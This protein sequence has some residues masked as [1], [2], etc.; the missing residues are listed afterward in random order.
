[1]R[2]LR[3]PLL[4]LALPVL[5][6]TA[7]RPAQGRP[8]A[9]A[10][11]RGADTAA[12]GGLPAGALSAFRFRGIGPAFT[13]GRIGDIA[14]HPNKT[15]WYVAVASGGV[16]KTENAGTTW[17]PIFD[18]QG[19]YSIGTVT[20]DP[21]DPNTIWVGTGENN[22]QRSV[23]YGDGVYKS[24]DGG[25][26]WRNM[27]LKASEHIGMIAIDPRDSRVVYV[28]A[29]G[30]LWSEGGDRGLYKTTDGGETWERILA[31]AKW[32]GVNEV[33][34]DPRNPDIVLASTWQ[35][36]RH[37]WGYLAGGPESALHRSTDGGRTWKKLS[38]VP[39]GEGRIGLARSPSH[40]DVVYAIV[41]A[42]NNRG[43][44]FRSRDN[45]ASWSRQGAYSTISLYYQEIFVDPVNPDRVYAMDVRTMVSND[46]GR[47]FT[48]LGEAGKHVDNHAF[49]A[50][51]DDP[52]HLLIGSDGGLYESFDAGRTYHFFGNLPVTQFYKIDVDRNAP[53][54]NIYGGTQDNFSFGGPSRTTSN[55]GIRN[56]DWFVTN[57]GD[58]FQSRVDPTDHNIIYAESQ[59]GGLVRFDRRTGTSVRIVP[60]PEPG[61]A[62]S[63]WNWDSPILVSPHANTRLYFASQRLYRSDDRGDNWTA[64]SPDLTRNQQR[65]ELRMQGRLWSVDAVARNTSTSYNGNIV[66]LAESPR[67]EGL[68]YVGTDDGLIQV[69]EDNGATWR[70]VERFPGVPDTS[71]IAYV[72]PSAHDAN[73]VYAGINNY[74]RGD[75]RPYVLK[76]TDKGRTWRAITANL[77]ERGSVHVVR[78]DPV[79]AGL[80]F[81]GTEFGIFVSFDDGARWQQLRGGLPPIAVRDIAIQPEMDDLVVATFGRGLYIL[82]DYSALR[83]LTPAALRAEATM[84]P[85]KPALMYSLSSPLGGSGVSFQGASH[86]FAPNPPVGAT[87]TY[88]LRTALRSQRAQRQAREQALNRTGADVPFPG[89]EALKAEQDEEA[90]TVEMEITDPSGA[91]ISRF[92]APGGAGT[93]R[94]TWNLRWPSVAPVAGSGGGGFGGFGGGGGGGG[95][96]GAGAVQ[97]G[98]GPYVVPGTYR[99]QLFKRVDG[100]RSPLTEPAAFDVTLL[101]D[102]TVTPADRA[103]ALAFQRRAQELQRVVLGANA[104]MAETSTRLDAL[105]RAVQQ[106]TRATTLD[107]DVRAASARLRSIREQLSGDNTPGRYAEP[108]PLSLVGRM[109]R[110]ASFGSLAAPTGTQERQLEIVAREFPAIHAALKA[111]V[112]NDLPALERRAEAEGAPW[113][114]GRVPELPR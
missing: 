109:G 38:G 90:P 26:T 77:P 89:W 41:E 88:H 103:R 5:A 81:A 75:F 36:H 47:T 8:V 113:T 35:R 1:M 12:A 83:A 7:Q 9:S 50:D 72:T 57:G 18:G 22:A 76:S 107:A 105:Q 6:L 108:T 39:E 63:R 98:N 70:R 16:W 68:V 91:V 51:P 46:A 45:G 44:V 95:G 80:L 52:A 21:N 79:K 73:V 20:M 55:N 97:G 62:P 112:E 53:F 65:T 85:V 87:F 32:A 84:F 29:Q 106:V 43:G 104:L 3:L 61:E 82:D 99:A 64:I 67:Q 37:V 54:Y 101:P 2:S 48:P 58:G 25:R 71:Y 60:E 111:F 34:L 23:S 93:N 56:S 42:A 27:G 74:K 10:P 31:G 69:T 30:P 24:E 33:I 15:T 13:S 92:T 49:W 100:V 86:Y 94:V 59:N 66:A 110:A 96:G 28:A 78:E 19:S 11:T 4:A 17:S 102:A 40:P 14:V 114:P